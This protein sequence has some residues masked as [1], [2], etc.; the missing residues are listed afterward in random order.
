MTSLDHSATITAELR[1]ARQIVRLL[2][3]RQALVWELVEAPGPRQSDDV[4]L[5]DADGVLIAY[6]RPVAR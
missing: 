3:R 4:T 2:R 5:R 1:I 6:A